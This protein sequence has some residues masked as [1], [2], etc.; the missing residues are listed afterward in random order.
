[1]QGIKVSVNQGDAF[2]V[3]ADTLVLKFAQASYGLDRDIIKGFELLGHP[4]ESK[5]PKIWGFFFTDSRKITNT[6]NLLFIGTPPLRSFGYKEIREFGGK[7]LISLSSSDPRTKS[8][9]LTI[10]GPGYG[11]DEIEAFKAQVAGIVDSIESED[12]PAN[13]QEITF[14]ERSKGRAERLQAVLS[15]LFPDGYIPTPKSGGLKEIGK[16]S[17]ETLR[18]A[19]YSSES[20]KNVFVAMPFAQEFDDCFHYGIC[21]AVNACGYLCERADLQS[22]T[23]DVMEWI[24]RRIASADFVIADL[25]TAN[26]NVYLEIGYAWGLN[27]RT[28]LL[29]KD[30]KDLKF[31]I[32]GQ[33]CLSYASI[34]DL[35]TKLKSELNN[36]DL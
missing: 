18:S 8:V 12:Y 10:H 7:A 33:R 31:D 3:E 13:L 22:F 35:E 4:I 11:L 19:G 25:T 32:R 36:L 14:I 26:P 27:K 20:K 24:K 5:L 30:T 21:G 15:T 34:K 17:I 9:I 2:L 29:I 28:I 23:G 16:N 6:K 1:M